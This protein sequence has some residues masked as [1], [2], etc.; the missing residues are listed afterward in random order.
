MSNNNK[1]KEV[2][3]QKVNP[4]EEFN[5]SSQNESPFWAYIVLKTTDELN[6]TDSQR[7]MNSLKT[8]IKDNDAFRKFYIAIQNME[9]E[10]KRY[11]KS[12]DFPY[13]YHFLYQPSS[14]TVNLAQQIGCQSVIRSVGQKLVGEN[15]IIQRI[16]T[17]SVNGRNGIWM[18]KNGIAFDPTKIKTY[19][20]SK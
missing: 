8:G 10:V 13:D 2:E 17:D 3:K 11:F 19:P 14:P 1:G 6:A 9:N 20:A 18:S 12:D 4:L 5:R 7:L 15:I 16:D